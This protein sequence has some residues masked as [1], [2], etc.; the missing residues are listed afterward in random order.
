MV[1]ASRVLG[2]IFLITGVLNILLVHPV[3]GVFYFILT[4][5]YIPQTNKVLKRRLGFSISPLAM[6][7]F[8]LIVL[9]GTL[10]V[11]DLAEILGL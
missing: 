2:V 1:L 6:V 3:P 9:W 7:T 10:A 5:L 4:L 11:G 8:G